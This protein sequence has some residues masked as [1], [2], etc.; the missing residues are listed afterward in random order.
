M[1]KHQFEW[2]C[3]RCRAGQEWISRNRAKCLRCGAGREWI[4]KVDLEL[5]K[6]EKA[7]QPVNG[8]GR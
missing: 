6:V 7:T 8:G 5:E 3:H 4:E 1:A 2:R